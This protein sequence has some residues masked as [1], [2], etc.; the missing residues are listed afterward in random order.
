MSSDPLRTD[1]ADRRS[2]RRPGCGSRRQDRAAAS[3]RT[4]PLLRRAT[5]SS[6]STSGRAR[7]FS[8]AAMPARA[9]T[10]SAPA[11]RWPNASGEA[12][13]LLH[14]GTAAFRRG[15]A[16]EARRLLQAA[17][18]GGAPLEDAFP[19]LE[20]LNRMDAVPARRRRTIRRR[21]TGA[22]GRARSR[23]RRRQPGRGWRASRSTLVAFVVAVGAYAAVASSGDWRVLARP[24]E[25]SIGGDAGA[26]RHAMSCWRCRSAGKWR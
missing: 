26:R 4:R 6:P 11:A 18:D 14:G 10:S 7:C 17:I 3:R 24:A 15:D 2:M 20:R 16:G 23:A 8:I 25:R 19:M 1:T 9:R 5:T 12:E 21:S 13:E 22:R